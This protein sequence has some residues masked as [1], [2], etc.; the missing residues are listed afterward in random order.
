M[1]YLLL[2]IFKNVLFENK[3]LNKI[4]ILDKTTKNKIIMKTKN[5]MKSASKYFKSYFK[6]TKITVP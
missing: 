1:L 2:T 6:N 3:S 4:K 5:I